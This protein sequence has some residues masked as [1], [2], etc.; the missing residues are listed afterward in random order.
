MN[1]YRTTIDQMSLRKASESLLK[2]FSTKK[3]DTKMNKSKDL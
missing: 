1:K 3:R 2:T